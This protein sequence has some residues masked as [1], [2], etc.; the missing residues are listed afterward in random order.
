MGSC[1]SNCLK[2]LSGSPEYQ[3]IR[4]EDSF[5][6]QSTDVSAN[7]DVVA[8]DGR[9]DKSA[10]QSSVGGNLVIPSAGFFLKYE[11][12]DV[13]G[14]GSTANCHRC[15]RKSDGKQYA[16]KVIDKRQIE[17]KF[18]GLLEQFYVEIKV[19]S[20]LNHPNI[21]KLEDVFETADRIFI[22]MEIMN[23]G[24]LFDYVV[25]KGTLSEQ[26]AASIVR[27]ITSA[28]AHM[29]AHGVIHR[30]LKPE[31]LLLTNKGPNAEVKLIDFGLAK[32]ISS[33]AVAHSFLGT[34][35]YLAPEMLQRHTYDKAIDIWALGIIVFV[36]LCGCLPFDDDS[37]RITSEVVARKKFA[38]RFP[39]WASNLSSPAKDLLQKLLDVNPKTRITAEEALRHPWVTGKSATPNNYLQ[40][41]SVLGERRKDLKSPMTP[42]MQAMHNKL[43]EA[44]NASAAANSLG[45]IKEEANSKKKTA[46]AG[47][48]KDFGQANYGATDNSVRMQRKNS[49]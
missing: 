11:L 38:L 18:T 7:T 15:C 3:T 29:H 26:E 27:R 14:V 6:V 10:T 28:I 23:G 19:L 8:K 30:D 34:R 43:V 5:D 25:E 22:V 24:E 13:L 16:C 36:L 17:A 20:E 39:R 49:I 37:S 42:H 44:N 46:N 35:G 48:Q 21:I 47:G 12:K 45:V 32:K 41:P 40:S 4:N 31:N 2:A 9:Q 1:C 33:D